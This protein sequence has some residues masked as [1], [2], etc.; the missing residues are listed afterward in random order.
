[1]LRKKK[2]HADAPAPRMQSPRGA[3]IPP[4]ISVKT[5]KRQEKHN[6]I[7]GFFTWI[8]HE[9]NIP[10]NYDHVKLP[11]KKHIGIPLW[12]LESGQWRRGDIAFLY[13]PKTVVII[14]IHTREIT[15]EMKNKEGEE[16]GKGKE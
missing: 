11:V 5:N 9:L 7:L 3:F 13:D 10:C 4:G 12:Y 2:N 14:E 1:M 8:L 15:R 16:H 6:N